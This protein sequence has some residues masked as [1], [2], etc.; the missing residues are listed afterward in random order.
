MRICNGALILNPQGQ[1]DLTTFQK[2]S[3]LSG[4]LKKDFPNDFKAT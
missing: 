4:D 2:L 3:N 1:T